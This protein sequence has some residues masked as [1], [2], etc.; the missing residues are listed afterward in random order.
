MAKG[1][2]MWRGKELG[3]MV[4]PCDLAFLLGLGPSCRS[5]W[6]VCPSVTRSTLLGFK[7]YS[8]LASV[9]WNLMKTIS[10]HEYEN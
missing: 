3:P 6:F 4:T 2:K 9:N 10:E 5:K 7:D 8:Y 1:R